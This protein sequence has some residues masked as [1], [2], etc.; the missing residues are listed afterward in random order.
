MAVFPSFVVLEIRSDIYNMWIWEGFTIG[1][2]EF[3]P[4]AS[5]RQIQ[6]GIRHTEDSIQTGELCISTTAQG[7]ES[8]FNEASVVADRLVSLVSLGEGRRIHVYG[9]RCYD[10]TTSTEDPI[11]TRFRAV[12]RVILT[13]P[14][15]V[16][17]P[18]GMD[19]F[20]HQ[21][22]PMMNDSVFLQNT[23]MDLA[24]DFLNEG[25]SERV[26]ELRHMVVFFSLEV[27]TNA[28]V[29]DDRILSRAEWQTAKAALREAL[30][31]EYSFGEEKLE[32]VICSLGS[33]NRLSISEKASRLLDDLGLRQHSEIVSLANSMRNDI[34][35]GR[36]VAARYGGI[37]PLALTR[38]LS[39]LL[40]RVVLSKF[41]FDL[42]ENIFTPIVTE[43]SLAQM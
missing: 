23:K 16:V 24:L 7:V 41:R 13:P 36:G 31:G 27:L 14:N 39:T 5:Q 4:L 10:D 43:S 40:I 42:N 3:V 2:A 8:A 18:W 1:T 28:H 25:I 38:M 22:Y 6:E 33:C 34:A 12:R 19:S 9:Q 32:R 21:T 30:G 17:V 37:N 26:L 35:H 29:S 15:R 11:E 20:L